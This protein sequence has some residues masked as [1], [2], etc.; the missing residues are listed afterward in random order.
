MCIF[1]SLFQYLIFTILINSKHSLGLIM[2]ETQ[3]I[4][5]DQW[6]NNTSSFLLIIY[7]KQHSEYVNNKA[8][9]LESILNSSLVLFL[10]YMFIQNQF[11]KI[12]FKDF[13]TFY[14]FEGNQY[15][16]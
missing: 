6:L 14:A 9:L 11:D 5:N 4:N 2:Q 8:C 7:N 1:E 15:L 13:G 3:P 16:R 10:L 12:N